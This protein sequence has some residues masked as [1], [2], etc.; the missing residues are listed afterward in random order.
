MNVLI[1]MDAVLSNITRTVPV[2][3]N[4]CTQAYLNIAE[5]Q[6]TPMTIGFD[7]VSQGYASSDWQGVGGGLM[8]I[9]SRALTIASSVSGTEQDVKPTNYDN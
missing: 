7:K 6:Q 4:F 3:I 8:L 1:S 2:Y 5:G 9:T